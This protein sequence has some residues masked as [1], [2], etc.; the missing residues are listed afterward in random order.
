[1]AKDT[2]Y[3][4]VPFDED[5]PD[6]VHVFLSED[7]RRVRCEEWYEGELCSEL[8]E[9]PVRAVPHTPGKILDLPENWVAS[10]PERPK[11]GG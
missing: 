7:G 4:Q 11:D 10:L 9:F 5:M 1:M 6:G 2:Q 3:D 8:G